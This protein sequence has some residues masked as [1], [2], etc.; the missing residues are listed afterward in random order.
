MKM[1]LE[2]L[3]ES[4]QRQDIP[5]AP[6]VHTILVVTCSVPLGDS[7]LVT[8]EAEANSD[9]GQIRGVERVDIKLQVVS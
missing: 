3:E 6:I 7:V 9:P 1:F 4:R 8:E 5:S 2:S